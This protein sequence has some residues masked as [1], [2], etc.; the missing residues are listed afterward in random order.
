MRAKLAPFGHL[1]VFLA[2]NG[3]TLGHMAGLPWRQLSSG[4]SFWRHVTFQNRKWHV[5][6]VAGLKQRPLSNGKLFRGHV[7]FQGRK[8][9]EP[10]TS[11]VI[12]QYGNKFFAVQRHH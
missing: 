7:T 11:H 2:A 8:P 3:S 6:Q 5:G 10:A 9:N 1:A 12:S 4:E